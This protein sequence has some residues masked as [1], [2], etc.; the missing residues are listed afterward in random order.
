MEA[1]PGSECAQLL[2]GSPSAWLMGAAAFRGAAPPKAGGHPSATSLWKVTEHGCFLDQL[3][4]SC[5]TE[6]DLGGSCTLLGLAT[7]GCFL[8]RH[9]QSSH[10]WLKL[11]VLG[12][13][14]DGSLPKP[15]GVDGRDL[16][17]KLNDELNHKESFC[18][19]QY[20]ETRLLLRIFLGCFSAKIT[21]WYI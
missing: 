20:C 5:I 14:L 2:P 16:N 7:H 21:K 1:T 6:A 9:L 4:H 12:R 8:D 3:W 11:T 10:T 15:V 13:F 17:C 18:G 19:I